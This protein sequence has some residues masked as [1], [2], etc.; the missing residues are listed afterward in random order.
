MLDL[1]AQL[2]KAIQDSK[3]SH[4][5]IARGSGVAQPVISRFVSGE[6]GI[7][8]VT[9]NKLADYLGVRFR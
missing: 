5:E 9:A 7:S 8:L 6:R 2:R 1:S 3:Q 4:N